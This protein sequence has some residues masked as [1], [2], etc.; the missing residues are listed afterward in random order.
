MGRDAWSGAG[1]FHWCRNSGWQSVKITS[2]V[3]RQVPQATDRMQITKDS[4]ENIDNMFSCIVGLDQ[5]K[6]TNTNNNS[7]IC[8]K[9]RTLIW[10]WVPQFTQK[11][12]E[13]IEF[14]QKTQFKIPY[15]KASYTVTKKIF[16]N[17]CLAKKNTFLRTYYRIEFKHPIA[18]HWEKP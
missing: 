15:V 1:C 12:F 13:V 18:N 14:I 7:G 10:F 4:Q 9:Q 17:L 8:K 16:K 5:S 3:W 2:I 11:E 6:I